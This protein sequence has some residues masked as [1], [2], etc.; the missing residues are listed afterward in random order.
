[1][2]QERWKDPKRRERR[3]RKATQKARGRI[4]YKRNTQE[5]QEVIKIMRVR[6]I[7]SKEKT[8]KMEG[9]LIEIQRRLYEVRNKLRR[10]EEE[11]ERLK[12]EGERKEN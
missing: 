3:E 9:R 10:V 11:I 5:K 12:K 8:V 2:E 4:T 6:V 1:M 7:E